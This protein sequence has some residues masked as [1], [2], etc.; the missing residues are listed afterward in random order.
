[1]EVLNML[2]NGQYIL[3]QLTAFS[4]GV[5]SMPVTEN[6][7]SGYWYLLAFPIVY[8]ILN[9]GI[10]FVQQTKRAKELQI[11]RKEFLH[12][13]EQL[14]KAGKQAQ[15]LNQKYVQVRSVKSFRSIYD[16]SKL[17]KRIIAIVRKDPQKF[18]MIEDFFYAHLPS[19][20]ELADKYALLTKE[21]VTGTDIHLALN[22]AR[23]T[24][25]GLHET[26]ELDLKQALAT[27]IE[28]LRLELDFAK[29]KNDSRRV[30]HLDDS[31]K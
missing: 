3:R 23:T 15:A 27:D 24:L 9:K 17:S 6:F 22:D 7:V 19:A 14:I 2:T 25:K 12:I 28:S 13:D 10:L 4:L 16:M 21:Q 26:M 1:M 8:F 31:E 18:Y 11:S 5:I 29:I 30:T 20:V